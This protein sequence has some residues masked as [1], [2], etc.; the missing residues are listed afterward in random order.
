MKFS[1]GRL[2]VLYQLG[3][4]VSNC[5]LSDNCHEIPTLPYPFDQEL[6][7]RDTDV[8]IGDRKNLVNEDE[9]LPAEPAHAQCLALRQLPCHPR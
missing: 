2:E 1:P 7:K 4:L 6:I 3:S 8:Y 9:G 5:I